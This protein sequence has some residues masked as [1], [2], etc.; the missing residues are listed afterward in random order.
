MRPLI[1]AILLSLAPPALAQ[2]YANLAL[3]ERLQLV[4]CFT[5]TMT[6]DKSKL[7][8]GVEI[9][10][11][12]QAICGREIEWTKR[13]A[14]AETAEQLIACMMNRAQ[15]IYKSRGSDTIDDYQACDKYLR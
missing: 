8:P 13:T 6:I 11:L 3:E 9:G 1:A 7:G 15:E 10:E 12:L 2:D 4:M 5:D 14:E